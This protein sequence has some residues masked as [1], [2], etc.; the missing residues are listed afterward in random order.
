MVLGNGSTGSP[1]PM[2]N[3][4]EKNVDFLNRLVSIKEY[5]LVISIFFVTKACAIHAPLLVWGTLIIIPT[6]CNRNNHFEKTLCNTLIFKLYIDL[7]LMMRATFTVMT[8]LA[9]VLA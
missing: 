2:I 9:S 1:S 4:I 6:L 3:K 5:I 8:S 7:Y